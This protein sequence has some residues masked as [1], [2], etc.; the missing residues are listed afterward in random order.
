MIYSVSAVLSAPCDGEEPIVVVVEVRDGAVVAQSQYG[1]FGAGIGV[2]ALGTGMGV[3]A[4][5]ARVA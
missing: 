2:G 5:G 4:S 3:G 1:L